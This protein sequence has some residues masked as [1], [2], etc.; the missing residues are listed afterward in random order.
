MI[1]N[2]IKIAWRN[3]IR[4]RT[5][6]FVNIT[7][8]TIGLSAC[9]LLV[10]FARFQLSFDTFHE[11]SDRIYRMTSVTET[12]NEVIERA[13]TPV[14][15]V[16]TLKDELP[17]VDKATH[18]S[19][20]NRV[21]IKIGQE[22]VSVQDFYWADQDFFDIFSVSV[23]RG[24]R[25]EYLKNLDSIVI[26]ESVAN[27]H[28]RNE[29][30]LGKTIQ[31]D[32]NLYTV[33]GVIDDWPVNSHFHPQFIATFNSFSTPED[34]SWFSFLT[35]TYFLLNEN[36]SAEEFTNKLSP[37]LENH[38]GEAA[39]E[40]GYQFTYTPQAL[41]DIH[42][43]SN[44]EGELEQNGSITTIYV[45]LSIALL[46]LFNACVNY[47]NLSTAQARKRATEVG[48]R[49]TFG[50]GRRNLIFQFLGETFLVTGL[51][52][53]L[54]LIVIETILPIF[55]NLFN[56]GLNSD[57][58]FEPMTMGIF[59]GIM[60]ITSLLA[61]L[62]PAF[63][64]T[65]FSPREV[66]KGQMN[67]KSGSSFSLRRKGM[68][69]FQFLV[70]IVLMVSSLVI[71]KQLQFIQ[72][73]DL[74]FDEQNLVVIPFSY[75]GERKGFEPLKDKLLAN[76]DIR[77]ITSAPMYPGRGY[78]NTQHWLPGETDGEF[79]QM[80]FVGPNFLEVFGVNLVKGRDF[81]A[82]N[83]EAN[84]QSVI[85]NETAVQRLGLGENPIGK[86]ISRT[87]P[88]ADERPMYEVVGVIEDFN[89]ESLR[90][91]IQPLVL[92]S[93]NFNVNMIVRIAPDQTDETLD[94]MSAAFNDVN[95]A[96]SFEYHFVSDFLADF[97]RSDQ[98]FLEIIISFT[99]LAVFIAGIGLFG[100]VGYFIQN[101]TK[102]L[103][104]RKVLGATAAN[105][106]SLLSKDFLKLVLLGFVIAIP[107]AWYAMNQWLTDFAYRIEISPGMFILAGTAALVIALL[108][109]SWQSIKAALRNPVES[110]RSE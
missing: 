41:T 83:A 52:F 63:Y 40:A 96:A 101:R 1:Q 95:P 61:G 12:A 2:Y 25:S 13:N 7:G 59:L 108:T 51:S 99:V 44:L 34:D 3:L 32:S 29:N 49:K 4:D 77:G 10:L 18:L 56:Q 66:L 43:H 17:E 55:N 14:P 65:S 90:E 31:L 86:R 54:S 72:Q 24:N 81:Y 68:I 38:F 30:P 22:T 110:L 48:I 8:L 100:L 94:F 5:Y 46:I 9:L 21:R 75:D 23:L 91:A 62:Y 85:V 42:L 11:K 39:E 87:D 98:N 73:K 74:G 80:G 67:L 89:T 70:S 27:T 82:E 33:T 58:L 26:T 60:T 103:A 93:I 57:M 88:N 109:V 79:T 37:V 107:I 6:S 15:L 76:P 45:V 106:I 35:R 71:L 50:S 78:V 16:Q 69:V 53:L 105:I 36:A 104:I 102:E 47:I 84:A 19:R 64:L 20:T 28:F 97:Y 92:Y